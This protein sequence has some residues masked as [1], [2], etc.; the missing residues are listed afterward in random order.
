MKVPLELV[1]RPETDPAIARCRFYRTIRIHSDRPA[2]ITT[3][4]DKVL[5][6][7]GGL[8]GSLSVFV[9]PAAR[10]AKPIEHNQ[11]ALF[12]VT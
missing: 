2:M 4:V 3:L 6:P 8:V 11:F 7:V 12:Y 9:L 5:L 1:E 10:I